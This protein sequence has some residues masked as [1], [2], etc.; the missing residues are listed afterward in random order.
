M[1]KRRDQEQSGWPAINGK[2][3]NPFNNK[4]F[5]LSNYLF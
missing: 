2:N 4:N 5:E 1:T 3:F